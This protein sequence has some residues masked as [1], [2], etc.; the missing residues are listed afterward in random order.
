MAE[1]IE[2][3]LA[4]KERMYQLQLPMYEDQ[5]K[6]TSKVVAEEYI[7]AFE[8]FAAMDKGTK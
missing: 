1:R 3:G 4:N 6:R 8:Y 2:Y 7:A 5:K